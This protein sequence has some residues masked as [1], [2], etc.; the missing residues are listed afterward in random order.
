MNFHFHFIVSLDLFSKSIWNSNPFM[1]QILWLK[2]SMVL[3]SCRFW[4]QILEMF[5][6]S[7]IHIIFNKWTFI[8]P[9]SNLMAVCATW[10]VR[11]WNFVHTT[12]LSTPIPWNSSNNAST[13]LI[14]FGFIILYFNNHMYIFCYCWL[15]SW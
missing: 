7:L 11:S 12:N 13:M 2:I 5:N 14:K 4:I 10:R 15:C 8:D 6:K 9:M 1:V 3:C